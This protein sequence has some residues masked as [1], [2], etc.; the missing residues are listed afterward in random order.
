MLLLR[1]GEERWMLTFFFARER[2]RGTNE[3]TGVSPGNV[4]GIEPRGF[5]TLRDQSCQARCVFEPQLFTRGEQ[6]RRSDLNFSHH[7]KSKI[8]VTD[9]KVLRKKLVLRKFPNIT[10]WGSFDESVFLI[11]N[12]RFKSAVST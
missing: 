11:R 6:R 7:V 3:G 12:L 9:K 10:N 8:P 4:L 5:E 2:K 1:R